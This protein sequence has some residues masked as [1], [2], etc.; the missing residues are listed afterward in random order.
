L[1]WNDI[2]VRRAVA[3]HHVPPARLN[4]LPRRVKDAIARALQQMRTENHALAVRRKFSLATVKS[5]GQ[6]LLPGP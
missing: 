2:A 4:S 6:T 5:K 3:A 1:F